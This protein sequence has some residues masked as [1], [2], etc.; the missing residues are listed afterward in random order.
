MFRLLVVFNTLLLTYICH[1]F[2]ATAFELRICVLLRLYLYSKNWYSYPT[3]TREVGTRT[4][5]RTRTRESDIRTRLVLEKS[6]LA[7]LC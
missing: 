5:T 6:V 7:H 4:R 3:R 1:I 2:S